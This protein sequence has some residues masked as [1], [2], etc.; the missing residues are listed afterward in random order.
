MLRYVFFGRSCVESINTQMK[1]GIIWRKT[2][3]THQENKDRTSKKQNVKPKQKQPHLQAE[4]YVTSPV[5]HFVRI[6]GV[7]QY[8]YFMLQQVLA[9]DG[10]TAQRL[11]A[12]SIISRC[13]LTTWHLPLHKYVD[14][15]KGT[16]HQWDPL[17][18][19]SVN[20]RYKLMLNLHHTPSPK[21]N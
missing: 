4:L 7:L 20:V 13:C 19:L 12:F 17:L 15:N 21:Q 2:L 3:T 1:L 14:R 10:L 5:T 8:K 9:E 11:L 16:S 6:V 18:F